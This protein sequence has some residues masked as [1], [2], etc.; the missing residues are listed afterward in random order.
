MFRMF[1]SMLPQFANDERPVLFLP[2]QISHDTEV[3]Q[4]PDPRRGGR[5]ARIGANE[6][7]RSVHDRIPV[8]LAREDSPCGWQKT[9]SR[10][11]AEPVLPLSVRAHR[12]APS[13][14]RG[15]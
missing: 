7:M 1:K 4:H 14:N 2:G 6:A 12:N 5:E 9:A 13:I 3:F 8:I 10:P 15:R 11:P